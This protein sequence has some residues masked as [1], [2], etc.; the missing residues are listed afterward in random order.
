MVLNALHTDALSG[1][2]SQDQLELL[3]SIDQLRLQ[4][5]SHYVS[6]P[7]IIV[8]GDQ[9]SGKSSVL[10][11][12]SGV[13]FPVKA[14][15]CTRFP[16][17]LVLRRTPQ[18]SSSVAIVPHKLRSE[19]ERR[20]LAGF[21]EKLEGFDGLEQVIENAKMAMG[22]SEHSK[23]FCND[24]LR[25]EITGP[26][27]P[28]LTIV[29]LPGLIHSETKNQTASDI[30]L[31]QQVVQDYMK[32]PRSIILAVVSAKN[33]FA[34]QIVLKL[35]RLADPIGS[36]TLGVITKPDTLVPGSESEALYISLARNQEVDFRLGWHVL[37]NMDSETGKWSLEQRDSLE[38]EFFSKGSWKA[39]PKPIM[40]IG[41][42]RNKLSKVLLRQIA[43]EL[44]SLVE[45]IEAK[46]ITC[47]AQLEKLGKPRSTVDEQ[48]LY[49]LQASQ[50]FQS[51]VKASTDG[52][53]N[54]EFFED[55]SSSRGYNQRIR[56]VIQNLNQKF[57]TQMT[58]YGHG[59]QITECSHSHQS[60]AEQVRAE[61]PEKVTPITRTE[62]IAHIQTLMHAT[63]GRELPG[64]FN[65]MI[66]AD[67]FIEQSQPWKSLVENHVLST[68]NSAKDFLWLIIAH[69]SDPLSSN[70]L[71]TQVFEP[72]LRRI[73]EAM[74]A[75]MREILE[76]HRHSHPITHNHSFSEA[77]Q[78]ARL[79]R[80]ESHFASILD[81][82]LGTSNE[83]GTVHISR[84]INIMQLKI[85]LT[86]SNEHDSEQFAAHEALDCMEAYYQVALK[87]FIDD[88]LVYIIEMKL[89]SA[90]QH[91]F[92][93]V[94]VYQMKTAVV[95]R[96]A[97]ESEESKYERSELE[98][99]LK[100]LRIGS[101][102]CKHFVGSW[103]LEQLRSMFLDEKITSKKKDTRGYWYPSSNESLT[104]D[105]PQ[106]ETTTPSKDQMDTPCLEEDESL[107]EPPM[108]H[109][110]KKDRKKDKK[111]KQKMQENEWEPT[112]LMEAPEESI[113]I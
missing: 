47:H 31:I 77:L 28:H 13:H 99:Q 108:R 82:H 25:V 81:A 12:I 29:D 69:I 59:R 96:I 104:D 9:S 26:D 54:D 37:K 65:P 113:G 30:E 72:A 62:F 73:L 110:S 35:A 49:L 85:D 15:L 89:M 20:L 111:K 57:A 66:V 39:L 58:K 106:P 109:I 38:Q 3:N 40:A 87:R 41:E 91:I 90:L 19:S 100:I 14:S 22:V 51:L 48:R 74:K 80:H 2:C 88:V 60:Y 18:A 68:W 4:G 8:C 75:K 112:E 42:L 44:P 63:R 76:P 34:N 52:T 7:Q 53:Y 16:T 24:L 61:I 70:L 1:L 21:H 10:E 17:E 78:K 6:L 95:S 11:A 105:S 64:T 45:E 23:A 71:Y 33:D 56:A 50:S 67:L 107:F 84:Y 103:T 101:E 27:R 92:S 98:K 94:S 32:E 36:R 102:T 97:G 46:I 5:I 86:L 83:S 93:P 55:A 79:Q 43:S